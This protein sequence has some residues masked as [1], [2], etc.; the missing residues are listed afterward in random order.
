V[1]YQVSVGVDRRPARVVLANTTS[2][3]GTFTVRK[4]HRYLFTVVGLGADGTETTS[5]SYAVRG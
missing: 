2:T 3:S 1:H 4:G 5:S